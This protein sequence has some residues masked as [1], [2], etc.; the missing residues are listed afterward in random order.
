MGQLQPQSLQSLLPLWHVGRAC[1]ACSLCAHPG[2]EVCH[3][4]CEGAPLCRRL[5]NNLC[6]CPCSNLCW[7]PCNNLCWCPCNS[8]RHSCNLDRWSL[9]CDPCTSFWCS[10]SCNALHASILCVSPADPVLHN[11]MMNDSS[12]PDIKRVSIRSFMPKGTCV[13][14]VTIPIGSAGACTAPRHGYA[15]VTGLRLAVL[16]NVSELPPES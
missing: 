5:C 10:I 13:L 12:H 6:W 3:S 2:V 7:C 1:S 9:R 4:A 15:P 8:S 11:N 16:T 14:E